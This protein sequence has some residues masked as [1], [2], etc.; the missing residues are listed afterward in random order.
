MPSG[1]NTPSVPFLTR[2][3]VA[4]GRVK[5]GLKVFEREV[6]PRKPDSES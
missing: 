5:K 6:N 1:R 3:F 4:V 2:G